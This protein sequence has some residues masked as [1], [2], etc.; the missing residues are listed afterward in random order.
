VLGKRRAILVDDLWR[1]RMPGVGVKCGG[2]MD[3]VDPRR[4]AIL[5]AYGESG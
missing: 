5:A 4:C 2:G 1:K 3:E